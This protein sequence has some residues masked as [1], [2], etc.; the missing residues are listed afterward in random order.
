M[1]KAV[2]DFGDQEKDD[3]VRRA[4]CDQSAAFTFALLKKCEAVI[5][6]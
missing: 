4:A 1:V 3:R 5:D 6:E 2:S